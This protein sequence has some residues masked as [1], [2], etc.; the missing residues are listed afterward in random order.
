M[1]LADE[2]L[3]GF[4]ID[5]KTIRPA[6]LRG[7]LDGILS[8]TDLPLA[9]TNTKE[10]GHGE[11]VGDA[12]ALSLV[13]KDLVMLQL[14]GKPQAVRLYTKLYGIINAGGTIKLPE[15]EMLEVMGTEYTKVVNYYRALSTAVQVLNS[16]IKDA[17]VLY[18]QYDKVG[19]F[20]VLKGT[21]QGDYMSALATSG[22]QSPATIDKVFELCI[23]RGIDE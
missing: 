4:D 20:T 18:Y 5:P 3:K 2:Y 14:W 23:E 10:L 17:L 6:A 21:T 1:G 9:V 16:T 13:S 12:E 11:F 22:L 7:I 19:E 8:A 15:S